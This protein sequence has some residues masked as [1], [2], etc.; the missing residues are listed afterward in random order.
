MPALAAA[1]PQDRA[2]PTPRA[3]GD[4][5]LDSPRQVRS[6]SMARD[7]DED[8]V[9]EPPEGRHSRDRAR[10]DFWRDWRASLAGAGL[11]LALL[12]LVLVLVLSR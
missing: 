12:V 7:D 9:G 1:T 4:R 6:P 5:Y 10:P 8:W 3:G 2:A 11:A